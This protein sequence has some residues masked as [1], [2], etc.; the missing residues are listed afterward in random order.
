MA[1][2]GVLLVV[3]LGLGGLTLTGAL[4]RGQRRGPALLAGLAFPVTWAVWYAR[5]EAAANR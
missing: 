1:F 2:V 5:D 4:R 3:W